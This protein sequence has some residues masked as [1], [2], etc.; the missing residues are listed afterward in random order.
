MNISTLR[1]RSEARRSRDSIIGGH[2]LCSVSLPTKPTVMGFASVVFVHG[3]HQNL[4][5]TVL[6][7][8]SETNTIIRCVLSKLA[9]GIIV[10]CL[11]VITLGLGILFEKS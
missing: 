6:V 10:T 9:K 8:S 11:P 2:K 7:R 1:V 4:L 3:I 5:S